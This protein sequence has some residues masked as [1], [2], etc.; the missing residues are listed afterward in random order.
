MLPV[1]IV[2]GGL[3]G[4]NCARVLHK[5]NVPFLLFEAGNDSGGRVTTEVVDD[6]RLDFGFQVLHTAY[7]EAKHALHYPSLHLHKFYPGAEIF[8]NGKWH[9]LADPWRKPWSAP[10]TLA[11][12]IGTIKDRM[13]LAHLQS[14]V[15]RGSVESLFARQ[16]VPTRRRLE[17]FGFSRDFIDGFFKPFY[18]GVFLDPEL[19]TSRRMFD[20]MFRMFG[21]GDVAIPA[22]GMMMIPLQL[23]LGLPR[24]ALFFNTPVAQVHPD[25]VKLADGRVVGARAVVVAV[26]GPAASKLLGLPPVKTRATTTLHFATN[27]SPLSRPIIALDGEG[28]GPVNHLAVPSMVSQEY[29]PKAC[30]LIA[31]NVIEPAALVPDEPLLKQVLAQMTRWFGSQVE[32][33]HLLRIH[34]I[35][36]ALPAQP[37]GWLEPADRPVVLPSQVFVAGDHRTTASI[38]GALRSGRLAAEGVMLSGFRRNLPEPRPVR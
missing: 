12:R 24:H 15:G 23:R 31:C 37:P 22:K 16:D 34:R 32:A 7:P 27:K 21:Q 5:N 13:L 35:R 6:Y 4:L 28:E 29:A 8:R 17:E 10:A 38:D 9:L 20:F 30:H 11:A 33:W 26:D 25:Q 1:V 3:A 19:N 14:D 36:H 18:R 2:G